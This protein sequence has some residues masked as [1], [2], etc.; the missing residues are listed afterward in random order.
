MS[1]NTSRYTIESLESVRGVLALIVLL[2]HGWQT[3]VRPCWP[4]GVL[5]TVVGILARLA[6]VGFFVVSGFAIANSISINRLRNEQFDVGEFCAARLFRIT[7]PLLII[8]ALTYF[9][10]VG[11]SACGWDQIDQMNAVRST[12][13]T[14]PFQQIL[15]LITGCVSGDL[16]GNWLNGPL[17]SLAYEIQLYVLAG[18]TAAIVWSTKFYKF[19]ASVASVL[20][21]AALVKLSFANGSSEMRLQFLCYG[22]FLIGVMGMLLIRSSPQSAKR[23]GI[24]VAILGIATVFLFDLDWTD[25]NSPE[26]IFAQASFAL[27]FSGILVSI[28]NVKPRISFFTRAG[29]YSY[30][31]YIA[32]FPILLAILFAQWHFS[33]WL[34]QPPFIIPNAIV[35]TFSVWFI[36]SSIGPRLERPREQLIASKRILHWAWSKIR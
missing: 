8:I 18:L 26:M 32:H 24:I 1:H 21:L 17:W 12:F 25:L 14:K 28:R 10:S 33:R 30:T 35:A 27:I 15:A 22:S 7:P 36:I 19:T 23:I 6:V 34:L 11:L 3:F 2:A 5:P 13:A 9:F 16:T 29:K 20:Y 31:L 4:E